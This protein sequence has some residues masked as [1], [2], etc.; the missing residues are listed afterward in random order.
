MSG[1]IDDFVKKSRKKKGKR[2]TLSMK[3]TQGSAGFCIR[4]SGDPEE[5]T[6]LAE[7]MNNIDLGEHQ[8]ES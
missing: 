6:K 1:A 3:K 5:I 8:Q 2:A 7:F 4:A